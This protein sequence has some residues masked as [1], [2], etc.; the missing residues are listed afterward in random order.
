MKITAIKKSVFALAIGALCMPV[1]AQSVIT[2]YDE[3][4]GQNE[5]I[6]LPEGLTANVD[7]L[8]NEWYSRTYLDKEEEC[9]MKDENPTFPTE[10]YV[11]RLQR[12][13]TIVELPHN[14]VIQKFIDM[15][16]GRLRK[17]VSFMLAANNFYN[18]IFEEALETYGVPHE[19][20]YL[21]VIE[22]ALN[23]KA[24]S[25][26]GAA[27]LW[28]F[29]VGTGKMYD[30]QINSLVDERRDPVK[31]SYAAAR[32]LKDLYDIY[33]DWHLVI[34]AYNCGPGN[35]NKAIHRAGEVKDYWKIYNY[36]PKETRGYVPSF[37]AATYIMNYY[38]DHNICPY[39]SRLPAQTD[40]IHV[41]NDIYMDQISHVCNVSMSEL[42][43]LNPQYRTNLIP[44]SG[45]YCILRLPSEAMAAFI[46]NQDSI[47]NYRR[48]DYQTKRRTV[49]IADQGTYTD[50][51]AS[52]SKR[53][54]RHRKQQEVAAGNGKKG[55][56]NKGGGS[57]NHIVKKGET[58]SAIARKNGTTVAKLQKLNGI[59]GSNIRAGQSIRVK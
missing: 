33:H 20:K 35:V 29:M 15:Y 39:E 17:S 12:L 34:A 45:V 38:C 26:V 52:T 36:L 4:L 21:P 48:S 28:Q 44:G 32:F 24:T 50:N 14:A 18:P 53:D 42:Q 57:A 25:P 10:V 9:H 13:P 43:A 55:K 23:P 51:S 11:D 19:L 5:E 41:S 59:K 27:G 8:L 31:S 54:R 22:S 2:V 49:E 7:S 46:T 16:S 58:L 47:Y 30:L 3:N 37:I 6:G 56:K 1:S 40:T